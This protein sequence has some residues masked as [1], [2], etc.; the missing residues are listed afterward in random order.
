MTRE[1]KTAGGIQSIIYSLKVAK[2]VGFRKFLKTIFSKNSCKVCAYGMGG[3]KGGM[4]N[5]LGH[6]PEICKKSIQSQLTDIQPCIDQ[7]IYT[8]KSIHD[9]KKLTGRE[10]ERLGRINHPL[11]KEKGSSHY[12]PMDWEDALNLV[13]N[14]YKATPARRTFFYSSGR[15]S[16]EAAFLLHLFARVYGTNNVNNCSFYCHQA[17]G[18][19]LTASLGSGT[20]T[21]HLEDLGKADMIFVMGA[22]PAANHPRFLKD[23]MLCRRRGGKVIIINPAKERG[24]VRFAI[25]SDLRSMLK[26]GDDIASM[27]LQPNIGGDIALLKGLAKGVIEKNAFDSDFIRQYTNGFDD[28]KSNIEAISWDEILDV[29]GIKK[30]DME[31]LADQYIQAKNVVFAWSM[32]ITHHVFGVENVESIIN[33][34]LLRGMVGKKSA[35]LLPLRGHSNVQGVGSMGVTPVLKKK[36]FDNIEEFLGIQLP[37]EAGMDTFACLQAAHRG[38]MDIAFLLGGNLYGSN[39]DSNFADEALARIP[40]KVFLNTTLN[41]GHFYGVGE[42]SLVLPV[43]ARDE[44]KQPTTQESMF[45]FVRLSDGGVVRLNNTR[46]EVDIISDIASGVVASNRINF[47]EFKKHTMI[48]KAIAKTIPGFEKM[49]SIDET[50]EEFQIKG[51]I[52]HDPKFATENQKAFFKVVHIPKFKGEEDQLRMMSVR[53]EGQFNTIIYEDEDILRGQKNRW[54]VM[55]NKKDLE[56][57]RI[58]INAKVTIESEAGKMEHVTARSFDISPGNV[59][60]YFPESNRLIPGHIDPRSKTPSFKCILVKI[61]N[62]N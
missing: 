3:Q 7:N 53:S 12:V 25:P 47:L 27:Y 54:I 17:S 43:A 8:Q 57:L 48:R 40:F 19:G 60:T 41:L 59:I 24:L 21:I 14:K 20:A 26:G 38:K 18:V 13:I 50:K 35:G 10:L 11:Y 36:I 28:Y 44:E 1:S 29:S 22:N 5:E 33:V 39:P 4:R 62:E 31:D 45:N 30:E 56:R 46:S 49:D 58:K 9:F 51:R 55:M 37:R 16:N 23:L 34:A 2:E 6:F 15:S 61:Y 32:G 42:E 52:F